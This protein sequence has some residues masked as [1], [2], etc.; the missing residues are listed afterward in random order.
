MLSANINLVASISS[1]KL[2]ICVIVGN[3]LAHIERFLKSFSKIADE[4]VIV[5]AIGNAQPDD[6]I[7]RC[8]G[9]GVPIRIGEY[10][11]AG[12]ERREWP[13]VDDFAAARQESFDLA[14]GD[15]LAWFDCDD[16]WPEDNP[17]NDELVR[18]IKAGEMEEYSR[19]HISYQVP[20]AGAMVARERFAKRKANPKWVNPI[21]E[22]M[23][24]DGRWF[25][26]ELATVLHAPLLD[27][28]ASAERNLR[29]L[30][31][32]TG[33]P[34]LY[35][36]QATLWFYKHRELMYLGKVDESLAAADKALTLLNAATVESKGDPQDSH[37]VLLYEILLVTAAI[38]LERGDASDARARAHGAVNVMPGRREAYAVLT[39]I[40]ASKRNY[41]K[42][43]AYASA[44][45]GIEEPTGINRTWT[46]R[47]LLY[48]WH[49]AFLFHQALRLNGQVER[50]EQEEESVFQMEGAAITIIHP[51]MLRADLALQTYGKFMGSAIN[52]GA[53]QYIF[54]IDDADDYSKDVLRAYKTVICPRGADLA[55][56][57][58]RKS[59]TGK[60]VEVIGDYSEPCKGWDRD[61]SGVKHPTLP[62]KLEAPYDG[63]PNIIKK[64]QETT[65]DVSFDPPLSR[66]I[67]CGKEGKS[68]HKDFQP[69]HCHFELGWEQGTSHVY[70]K[71]L[72][73]QGKLT[74]DDVIV[75]LPGREF[76][77]RTCFDR[78]I[79][80]H[81]FC[82]ETGL[83]YGKP[84]RDAGNDHTLDLVEYFE[85]NWHRYDDVYF[86]GESS[87]WNGGAWE[88][89][90][91]FRE[92]DSPPYV[93][94]GKNQDNSFLLMSLRKR[95]HESRRD[96]PDEFGKELLQKLHDELGLPI[97]L[98]GLN[99]P[100][101]GVE[102]V[103]GCTLQEFASL[104]QDPLCVGILGP[105]SGPN[106]L[107]GLLAPKDKPIIIF[108]MEFCPSINSNYPSGMGKCLNL[109]G[110]IRHWLPVNSSPSDIAAKA[111]EILL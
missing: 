17:E 107:A 41:G 62:W 34:D 109:N 105:H 98:V 84:Y 21:H 50:V 76:L 74:K 45:R 81:E 7:S 53:V 97:F 44:M 80:W 79:T 37:T 101:F 31:F 2:S 24:V 13:H 95:P 71:W 78:M 14:T 106:G 61:F 52:P 96:T 11:N 69:Q 82:K 35:S 91:S 36:D 15:W 77:Y 92:S 58:A 55:A 9:I 86:S 108:P 89:I 94:H 8:G 38:A 75:T 64:P 60:R 29:I 4:F 100:D 110:N 85:R 99:L 6:T 5:R 63:Y 49:G 66:Y 10:Y 1:M 3:E 72:L 87:T 18:R 22:E 51:T 23:Q 104:M 67:I 39:Q 12:D 111:K 33:R 47:D 25:Y 103:R 30:E 28:K 16:I 102:G 40:E 32:A 54:A 46:Q 65:S 88:L 83:Q 57:I 93:Y 90:Q 27:K 68:P 42:A 20:D 73:S 70:A 26:V 43:L 59:A 19:I 56:L 48:S